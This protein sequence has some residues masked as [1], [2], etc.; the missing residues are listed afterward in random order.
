[1]PLL[2]R[3]ENEISAEDFLHFAIVAKYL[4][5]RSKLDRLVII[6]FVIRYG[7]LYYLSVAKRRND[8]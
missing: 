3:I 7:A 2:S 1:M 8:K 5:S 4:K 6:K